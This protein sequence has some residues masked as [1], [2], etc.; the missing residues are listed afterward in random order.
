MAD[1]HICLQEQGY[2]GALLVPGDVAL[3]RM[4][5]ALGYEDMTKNTR[6]SCQAGEKISLEQNGEDFF[7]V[8]IENPHNASK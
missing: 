8:Q 5:R 2:A 4:Y 3:R 1:T 7:M 6:F